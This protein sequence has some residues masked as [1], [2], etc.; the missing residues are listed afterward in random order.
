MQNEIRT[1]H[2]HKQATSPTLVARFWKKVQKT[3]SCWLWTAS[4]TDFGYG[5]IY[6]GE[7]PT[8]VIG[9]HVLSWIIHHGAIPDGKC[10]LH[11]CPGGDN[12]AC[13]NPAHLWLGTKKQ[14]TRDMVSKGRFVHGRRYKLGDNTALKIRDRF[15]EGARIFEL[16][17]EF[18]VART[19]IHCIVTRRSYRHL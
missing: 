1:G 8:I 7:K 17:S 5:Q 6:G 15:N 18:N 11:N 4:K 12:P 19:T 10:V 3:E 9:A 2:S 13:V 16:T 14:N